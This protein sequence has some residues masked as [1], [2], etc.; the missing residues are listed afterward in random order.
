[1]IS[2]ED[3]FRILFT[4]AAEPM[5]KEE[6]TYEN[7]DA[8]IAAISNVLPPNIKDKV[9]F[10][11]GCVKLVILLDE[12]DFVIKVPFYGYTNGNKFIPYH[13]RLNSWNEYWNYCDEERVIWAK[14]VFCK[15]E[16]YFAKLD[17]LC[18]WGDIPIYIQPKC[19]PLIN[20]IPYSFEIS[21]R[22]M[23]MA[24]GFAYDFP[25]VPK[26]WMAVFID[27]Y[28]VG[29]MEKLLDFVQQEGLTDL[30]ND[31]IGFRNGEC[32]IFDYA[33]Y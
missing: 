12:A 3:T 27:K 13:N 16:N 1:M 28:G 26:I 33:E 7:S 11:K 10:K 20:M 6:L 29:E 4:E 32:I 19:T 9:R 5:Q 30:T 17:T 23:Y 2:M 18:H 15:L 31:N 22:S 14:A 8:F 21:E 25:L 24:Q